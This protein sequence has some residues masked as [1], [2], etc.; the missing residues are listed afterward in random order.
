[1]ISSEFRKAE[2]LAN[3]AAR[4]EATAA[5]GFDNNQPALRRCLKCLEPF[6]SVGFHHRLCKQC[7]PK[8]AGL[9]DNVHLPHAN[10]SD[11]EAEPAKREG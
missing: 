2:K 10:W 3:E 7:R 6:E 11:G 5:R 9:F 1:M 4:K 8:G